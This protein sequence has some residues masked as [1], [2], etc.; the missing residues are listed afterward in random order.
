[1]RFKGK[2]II[3]TGASGGIGSETVRLFA[4]EG[5]N[6][7]VNYFSSPRKAEKTV[8]VAR[9]HGVRRMWLR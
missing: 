8:A 4:E 2:S 6:I 7:T 1:M 3:V 5:A 9:S